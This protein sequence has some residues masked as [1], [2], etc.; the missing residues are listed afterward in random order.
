[1]KIKS[2][3]YKSPLKLRDLYEMGVKVTYHNGELLFKCN[4]KKGLKKIKNIAKED[5]MEITIEKN[6]KITTYYY[7]SDLIVEAILNSKGIFNLKLD[8]IEDEEYNNILKKYVENNE[9]LKTNSK[10]VFYRKNSNKKYFK[11]KK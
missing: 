4:N 2:H 10:V 5:G 7:E 3:K 11:F 9:L 6:D 1:M 8:L